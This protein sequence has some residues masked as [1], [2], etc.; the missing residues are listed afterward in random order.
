MLR[1]Y[2]DKVI[3]GD[4]RFTRREQLRPAISAENLVI[5]NGAG[6][7]LR[8]QITFNPESDSKGINVWAVGV[9]PICRLDVD[10][11]VHRDAGRS[12]KHS[13][14]TER[15]PASNL[16]TAVARA[17]LAGK[18][19]REVFQEFCTIANIRHEGQFVDP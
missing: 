11:Q 4:I 16:P 15:C 17:D 5:E 6:A 8:M 3:R 14:Q 13:L 18:T 1:D 10:G 2:P 7:E 19:L 12:H 9:G